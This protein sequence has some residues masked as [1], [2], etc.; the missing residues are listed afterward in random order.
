MANTNLKDFGTIGTKKPFSKAVGDKTGLSINKISTKIESLFSRPQSPILSS[1]DP[2]IN[3]DNKKSVKI[4]NR[5]NGK[6]SVIPVPTA[7]TSYNKYVGFINESKRS[8]PISI[9]KP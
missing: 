9:P 1:D 8:L 3:V 2:I 6:P 5:A 7:P 4:Y